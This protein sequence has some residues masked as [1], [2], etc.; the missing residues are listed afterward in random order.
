MYLHYW[1]LFSK[2]NKQYK[3]IENF[4]LTYLPYRKLGKFR[5]K[6]LIECKIDRELVYDVVAMTK[7]FEN[8]RILCSSIVL[9]FGK[10]RDC[11]AASTEYSPITNY[12]KNLESSKTLYKTRCGFQLTITQKKKRKEEY[13]LEIDLL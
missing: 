2:G 10:I 6:L 5:V 8:V 1:E 3:L 13:E 12:R 11:V 7:M 9:T 4:W